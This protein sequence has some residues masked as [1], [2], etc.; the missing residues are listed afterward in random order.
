MASVVIYCIN[1]EI[2]NFQKID[3]TQ[4]PSNFSG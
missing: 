3:F 4:K 2:R 1:T